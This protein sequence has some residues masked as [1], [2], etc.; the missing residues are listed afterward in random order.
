MGKWV[1]EEKMKSEDS[2]Q[3]FDDLKS[4]VVLSAFHTTAGFYLLPT[5]YQWCSIH[6][7]NMTWS[8]LYD[9]VFHFLK[10]DCELIQMMVVS[11]GNLS[12]GTY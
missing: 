12:Y 5:V 10:K 9:Y 3:S 4:R 1:E 2:L 6:R 11:F 7:M 8:V